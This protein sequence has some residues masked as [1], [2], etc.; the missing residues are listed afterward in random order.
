MRTLLLLWAAIAACGAPAGI[1]QYRGEIEKWRRNR[2]AKLKADDGW[3]TVSGLF[4]LKEGDNRVGAEPGAEVALPQ[5][6]PAKVGVIS[7]HGSHLEFKSIASSG[8]LVNGKPRAAAELKPDKTGKPD[9]LSLADLT[10]F[11]IEREHKFGV[12]LK[13][14]NASLRKRFSGL[15]WYPVQEK[16]RVTARWA[17]YNPPKKLVFD[18]VAGV[19][20]HAEAPG[21]AEFSLQG[22][23]LRLEPTV[24]DG[25]LFFVIR[26][27]T[28]GKTTY[29]ASRFL[30]ADMPKNGK[31]ILDFNKA[32]NPPC[33][34]TPYAT[35]PLPPPQNRLSIAVEAGELMYHSPDP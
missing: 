27:Q 21:Y 17:P 10:M 34:F 20:E 28:A 32:Y 8:V 7:R 26:D 14:K 24:D 30:Y 33:V 6:A 9:I 22:Q 31:V 4:W 13:D 15:K 35:C 12:R 19:K 29:P 3:L 11:I 2:E 5:G 18:T 23:T 16:W 1:E 25:A